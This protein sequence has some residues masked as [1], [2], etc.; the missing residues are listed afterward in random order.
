[1]MTRYGK[2]LLEI[3]AVSLLY[4]AFAQVGFLFAIPGANITLLWLPSGLAMAGVVLL[5][6]H[7]ALGVLA[8]AFLANFVTLGAGIDETPAL[9]ALAVAAGNASGALLAGTLFSRGIARNLLQLDSSHLLLFAGIAMASTLPG[10][11]WGA[12]QL[13]SGGTAGQEYL[14]AVLVW[15]AGDTLGIIIGFPLLYFVYSRYLQGHAPTVFVQQM[16][17]LSI[18]VLLSAIL[19]LYTM[20]LQRESLQLRFRYVAEVAFLSLDTAIEQIFQHQAQLVDEVASEMPPSRERFRDRAESI[21]Y[22][23]YRTRG[24]YALSW[25]PIILDQDREAME[26]MARSQG[27]ENFSIRELDAQGD[28]QVSPRKDLYVVVFHIEPLD[29]NLGALGFDI[30]SDPSRQR[31]IDQALLL[32]QPVLTPPLDLVQ[33]QGRELSPGALLLWPLR[34]EGRDG[35]GPFTGFVVAVI[36][37]DDLLNQT[38]AALISDASVTI[39]DVTDP[40]AAYL[41]YANDP[42]TA[43][44]QPATLSQERPFLMSQV[45][46]VGT[47][48]LQIFAEASPE[49]LTQNQSFTPL[50]VLFVS[51]L[52]S[53]L[54]TLAYF[55]RLRIAEARA[56]MLYRT[57]QIINSAP[58]A[59]VAMNNRGIVTEWNM[60]AVELF[61]YSEQDAVGKML[62]G[63]IVPERWRQAHAHA[64][65]HHDPL[66]VSS[67]INRTLEV[68][69]CRANGDEFPAELSVKSVS[70]NGANE[71]IGMIRDLS[72]KKLFEE[73]TRESQKMEA[74]GQLTGGLA[75]DFNNLL[76]IVI[77]NLDYLDLQRL[78]SQDAK[79]ARSALDAA[80]R[81]SKVTRSLM[82]V[83]RRQTLEVRSCEVNSQLQELT[84]LMETTAGKHAQLRIRLSPQPL[85]VSLDKTGFSNAI[86]NLLLNARD[87][88][89]A[90]TEKQIVISTQ[91]ILL[92]SDALELPQGRYAVITVQDNGTGI[93]DAIRSRVFEPFFTTKERGHGTGL[94]LSMVYGFA[95]QLHGTVQIDSVEEE[96]T[97]VRIYL[98]LLTSHDLAADVPRHEADQVA[99]VA[100]RTVLLVEDELFLRRIA[101]SMIADLGF[102]VLE[103]ESGDA[104]RELLRTQKVDILFTDIAMPGLLD[105]VQLAG[106]VSAHLP[107]V[108]IIVTTGYLDDQSRQVIAS[109]WQV[110]EK[111]YRRD[112]LNRVLS[113]G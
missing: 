112:D 106:W 53:L 29:A 93:P 15:W 78:G 19:Y 83:A 62:S 71:F 32:G 22:G 66:A 4:F 56:D 65:Q 6:N 12:F 92:G 81:A 102:R 39:F 33:N 36:R 7:A 76:G 37:Y 89:K 10:A 82:S 85:W 54:V 35:D 48:N 26:A 13:T 75:H 72:A 58:D 95:R 49:F 5:G 100:A 1:M 107:E 64:L 91:E 108:K 70:I 24:V 34:P 110:L 104:A 16:G 99:E 79:H 90:R 101:A 61:G 74:I 55:Q 98:P 23:E 28:L 94:G 17:V 20:N 77:A 11:F 31:T 43:L 21:L 47:R 3:L 57:S 27:Y 44:A 8:G 50:I 45:L 73:K 111:P 42:D 88:L 52:L 69:A 14:R 67:V 86:I 87:A 30:H 80:L 103:A 109:Q 18:G 59:M 113:A 46:D 60:A 97:T 40:A 105:G 63:L 25:N 51:L 84:P 9:T 68:T 96:G 2:P 41:L 38:S